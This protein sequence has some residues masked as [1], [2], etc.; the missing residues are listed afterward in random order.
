MQGIITDI[1]DEQEV[2]AQLM[3][4]SLRKDGGVV[5]AVMKAQANEK[6]TRGMAWHGMARPSEM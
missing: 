5:S 1:R 4:Q 2:T 6:D 3:R